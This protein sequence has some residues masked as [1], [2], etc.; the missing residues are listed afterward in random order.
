MLMSKIMMEPGMMMATDGTTPEVDTS[1]K[2]MMA[3]ATVYRGDN[4][5][6]TPITD[7]W[8]YGDW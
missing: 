7:H 8:K 4:S 2:N 3:D 6:G 5:D 1:A